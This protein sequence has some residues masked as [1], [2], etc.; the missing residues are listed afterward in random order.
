MNEPSSRGSR[1]GPPPI[2]F[3]LLGI[4]ALWLLFIQL[5][6]LLGSRPSLP[7][8]PAAA[9]LPGGGGGGTVSARAT[10]RSAFLARPDVPAGTTISIDGSTSMVLINE[11]LKTSFLNTYP[12]TVVNTA[13]TGS[14]NGIQALLGGS[15]NLAAISRPLTAAEQSKGLKAVPVAR[16]RI[17]IVV[18]AS[19]PFRR[20]L[21]SSQLQQI[22][23]GEI[24]NW[25]SIG[26]PDRP[27]RV[28]N[29]PS[30]SGTNQAF[31]E[32]VLGGADFGKTPNIT[33]LDRDATTPL[34]RLLGSDGIS[35]ATFDQVAD[36][37]TARVVAIDG[38][39]PDADSYPFQ[40]YLYYVYRKPFDPAVN[41]FL[42]FALSADGQSRIDAGIKEP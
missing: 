20:S 9:S 6:K 33:T 25:S 34:L 21:S 42:G 10:W 3:L 1:K 19:N 17:A 38:S 11:A 7:A 32:L 23:R 8:I 41:A 4:G 26:G 29:R 28:I 24:S 36:Q 27:I 40:R 16:D 13:A 14:D 5:P 37:Q 35:Y 2:V 30:V 15:V 31:R 22:F 18:G 39:M 12:G